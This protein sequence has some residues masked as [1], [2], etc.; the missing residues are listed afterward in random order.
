MQWLAIVVSLVLATRQMSEMRQS[1]GGSGGRKKLTKLE[2]GAG[3][4]ALKLSKYRPGILKH[5][6]SRGTPKQ[7]SL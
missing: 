4:G 6:L 3:S 1:R 2:Y 5:L 7:L